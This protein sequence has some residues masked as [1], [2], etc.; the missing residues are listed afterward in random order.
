MPS[1]IA[2]AK[3]PYLIIVIFYTWR[4]ELANHK[5]A[6]KRARQSIVKNERN[7]TTKKTIRTVEKKLREAI[8]NK[9]TDEAKTL[10][11]TFTSKIGK[12]AQKGILHRN[13][14]SRKIS[15]LSKSFAQMGK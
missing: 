10:L 2:Y 9:K 14:A 13:N 8:T 12:A 4:Q 1:D 6:A 11:H 3:S 15:R 7:A 5:S